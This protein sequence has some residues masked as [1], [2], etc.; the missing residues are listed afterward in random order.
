[1]KHLALLIFF[2]TFGVAAA[3][4]PLPSPEPKP[5]V[6][7]PAEAKL[8]NGKWYKVCL[9]KISWKKAKQKCELHSLHR[10]FAAW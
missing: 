10:G 9:E 8:F 4:P 5:P 3:A 1:M 6:G 7:V 2:V